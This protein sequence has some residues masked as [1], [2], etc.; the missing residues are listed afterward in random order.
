MLVWLPFVATVLSAAAGLPATETCFPTEAGL[1][2]FK[3]EWFCKQLA[4]AEERRLSGDPAYR[5]SYIPSFHA[6]RVVVAF[7]DKE[8]PTVIGKVLSGKGGYE[9]GRL[10]R[11]T[12]RVLSTDEWR[13]LERRLDNA[14]LWELPDKYSREGFDGAEWVLEGR[15]QGRYSLHDVWSPTDSTFPQYRKACVYMLELAGIAPDTTQL[16]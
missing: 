6:T 1:H 7:M 12:R 14:G 10:L 11:V 16:Y 5:F 13:L 15:N 8:R 9:P 4:A 2:S 3:A